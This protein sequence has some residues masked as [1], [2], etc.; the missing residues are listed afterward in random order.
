[1]FCL[2]LPDA[3]ELARTPDVGQPFSPSWVWGAGPE[4]PHLRVLAEAP[5]SALVPPQWV[6]LKREPRAAALSRTAGAALRIALPGPEQ[7]WVGLYRQGW[8]DKAVWIDGD[9]SERWAGSELFRSS[10]RL[11]RLDAIRRG[12]SWLLDHDLHLD[13]HERFA[14]P[15][16]LMELAGPAPRAG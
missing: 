1:M 9:H 12:L 16:V 13:G 10:V 7:G 5:L 6:P 14:L 8:L 15:E 11:D 4:L 2:V 3:P